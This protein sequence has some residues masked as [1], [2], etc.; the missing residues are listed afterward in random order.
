MLQHVLIVLACFYFLS[1]LRF[2]FSIW[3]FF[4]DALCF[5][6]LR[7]SLLWLFLLQLRQ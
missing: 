7:R 1:I 3:L 2:L 5:C 4:G 6:Y